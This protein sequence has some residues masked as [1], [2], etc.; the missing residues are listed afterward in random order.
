MSLTRRIA[1][2]T[3]RALPEVP[4]GRLAFKLAWPLRDAVG[5]K[6]HAATGRARHLRTFWLALMDND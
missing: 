2:S 1:H 4:E 6:S 3:W 5:L